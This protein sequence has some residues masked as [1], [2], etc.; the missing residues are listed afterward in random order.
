VIAAS[1]RWGDH[2]Q[3][4]AA[5]ALR[6]ARPAGLGTPERFAGPRCSLERRGLRGARCLGAVARRTAEEDWRD[7]RAKLVGQELR[8]GGA[9]EANGTDSAEGQDQEGWAYATPLIEEGSLL[10]SAPGD[11]FAINQQ[12]FHK[13]VIF[14]IEHGDSFTRGIILNR[15]TAFDTSD[16]QPVISK[17]EALENLVSSDQDQELAG[18][19]PPDKGKWNVWCG[20]DCQ[21]FNAHR[22]ADNEVAYFCIHCMDRFANQ[23][24]QIIRGVFLIDLAVARALVGTGEADKNDFLL[25]VGYCGWAPG[26]LQGELDRGGSWTMAAA[27]QRLLLGRLQDA[28]AALTLRVEAAL[29][30]RSSADG[31]TGSADAILA[32]ADVGDGIAEWR[33]LY[34]ALGPEFRAQ[35]EGNASAEGEHT[36]EMLRRWVDRCLIPARHR[37]P[38]VGPLAEEG[39]KLKLDAGTVLRGSP[40]SWLLGKPAERQS[41][42]QSFAVPGQYFHKAVLLLVRDYVRGDEEPSILVLLDGPAVGRSPDDESIEVFFGGPSQLGNQG[43]VFE[44]KAKKPFRFQG[45]VLLLPGVLEELLDLGAVEVAHGVDVQ[46]VLSAPRGERWEAAGGQIAEFKDAATAQLGD[47][48]K[49]MWYQRFLGIDP[50]CSE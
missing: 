47:V 21:G 36:D 15:P 11:H 41:F 4:D 5:A 34:S 32:A 44:V 17:S 6:W 10:L 48:Q 16:L 18:A 33:Q 29:A 22:D 40:T 37:P 23:S 38:E 28:Q 30:S 45:M 49:R 39:G 8:E 19:T 12:Y 43:G 20:G 2:G 26:Q 24:Q 14:I 42:D 35:V 1:L 50:A 13:A 27:D 46:D 9:N 3:P 31:S 7:F 25:L